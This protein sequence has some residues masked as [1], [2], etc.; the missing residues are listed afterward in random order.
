MD[1]ILVL[2]FWKI[3]I[4]VVWSWLSSI[5]IN[6]AIVELKAKG[7]RKKESHTRGER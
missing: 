2:N 3:I 6:R 5:N 4:T 1:V 7:V